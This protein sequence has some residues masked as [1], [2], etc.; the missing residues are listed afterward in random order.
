MARPKG[1]RASIRRISHRLA[2]AGLAIGGLSGA[3]II[4][5]VASATFGGHVTK[6]V[7][8]STAKNTKLGTILVSGKTR[9][10]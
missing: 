5:G 10:P 7:V 3:V 9:T 2:M 1:P 8:I 4:G 6:S